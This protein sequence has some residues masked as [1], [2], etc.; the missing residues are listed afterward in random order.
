MLMSGLVSAFIAGKVSD[1][2]GGKRKIFVYFSGTVMSIAS[3]ALAVNRSFVFCI[4]I[5][6][7]FGGAFGAFQ[8]VDYAL[9]LDVLPNA[10]S[11]AQD[12]GVWHVSLVIPQ[13]IHF[14]SMHFLK[15]VLVFS[16]SRR[17]KLP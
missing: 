8:A 3:L 10:H 6:T 14:F 5:A 7:V 9:V 2:A 1:A 16:F 17:L 4:V 11:S 12:L 13:L 15:L